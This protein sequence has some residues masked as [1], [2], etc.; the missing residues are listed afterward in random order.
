MKSLTEI[1]YDNSIASLKDKFSY[2]N[3]MELPKI[4]FVS[5]N[6]AIKATESDNKTISYIAN[7]LSNIA[8]LKNIHH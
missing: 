7:Q 4:K 3:K 6:V 2:K 5:L 8:P 1:N